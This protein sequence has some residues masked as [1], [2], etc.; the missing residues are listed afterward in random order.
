MFTVKYVAPNGEEN[1]SEH[2]HVIADR[3]DGETPSRPRVLVFDEIP[4]EHKGNNS[5][6]YVG[7]LERNTQWLH[8][9]IVYVM[10]SHGATVARYEL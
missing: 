2:R 1:I 4:E 7:P 8:G 10:N 3:T 5:G 6:V 9:G